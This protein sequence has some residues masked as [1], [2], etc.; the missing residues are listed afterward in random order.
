[1]DE[2]DR[3]KPEAVLADIALALH[4]G[5]TIEEW[6]ARR[7]GTNIILSNSDGS[8]NGVSVWRCLKRAWRRPARGRGESTTDSVTPF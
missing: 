5:E 1:M 2:D 4:R 7:F 8:I 6:N 3:A